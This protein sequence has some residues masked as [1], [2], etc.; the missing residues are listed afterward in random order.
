MKIFSKVFLAIILISQITVAQTSRFIYQVTMK[1]DSTNKSDVKTELARLDI[2]P[3]KSLFYGEKRVQ[4]DSLM[5]RMR[6]TR[7]FDRNAM[8]NLRS[9][10]DFIIEKMTVSSNKVVSIWCKA[11]ELFHS[12]VNI[13]HSGCIIVIT[14]APR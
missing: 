7:N 9:N 10:I 1:P 12:A 13:S 3:E 14:L 11:G 4:R 6:A 2:S 5:E 8:Q